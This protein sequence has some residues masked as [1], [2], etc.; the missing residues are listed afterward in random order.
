M[1]LSSFSLD[2][3]CFFLRSLFGP[4]FFGRTRARE[5]DTRSRKRRKARAKVRPFLRPARE[6]RR[7][8]TTWQTKA[9]RKYEFLV[10]LE[11]ANSRWAPC[12]CCACVAAVFFFGS[13]TQRLVYPK[14]IKGTRPFLSAGEAGAR[15]RC[16]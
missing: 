7:I 6:T 14:K 8:N 11:E 3:F 15:V 13:R 16:D 2:F 12:H 5:G 1:F 9:Q 10:W 4:L